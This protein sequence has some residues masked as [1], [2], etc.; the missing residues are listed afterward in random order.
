ML[1]FNGAYHSLYINND[2]ISHFSTFP[3]SFAIKSNVYFLTHQY[4]TIIIT[5]NHSA[6]Y[7]YLCTQF[8]EYI[9]L[10]DVTVVLYLYLCVP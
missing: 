5:A 6:P 3:A 1:P 9:A 4:L 10:A 7:P 2:A 8:Y